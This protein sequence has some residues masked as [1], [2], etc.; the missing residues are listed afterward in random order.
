MLRCRAP[1]LLVQQALIY[2]INFPFPLLTH[3]CPSLQKQVA[4]A[5]AK[6][7]SKLFLF[8]RTRT[9]VILACRRFF[10]LATPDVEVTSLTFF[11][12]PLQMPLLSCRPLMLPLPRP[13]LSPPPRLPTLSRTESVSLN[14]SGTSFRARVADHANLLKLPTCSYNS[15]MVRPYLPVS[16]P[17]DYE[18]L[19]F[20]AFVYLFI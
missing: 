17:V 8:G 9:V 5:A 1:E 10:W 3:P 4:A 7:A 6:A 2:K 19:I 20:S 15:L 16:S 11:P 12:P 13:L 18:E 14:L